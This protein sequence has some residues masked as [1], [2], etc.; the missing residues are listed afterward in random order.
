MEWKL[1]KFKELSVE[2]MYEILRVRDQ[3]F[4]VEQECPYQDIDSKDKNAYHLFAH[5]ND[6]IIAYLRI[7]EKSVSYDEISIGRVLISKDYRGK[8]LA[9]ELMLKAI[10]FIENNMN[11]K[12]IKISAQAYLLDFYRSLGFNEVSEVY[13][14][15]NIPH[16]DML[17]KKN[18]SI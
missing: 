11:E 4:I 1:K 5:D 14:E 12:E 6:A 7:L 16:I 15:D 9:R 17:Y 10:E 2:E 8:G 13:L 18:A 3:V